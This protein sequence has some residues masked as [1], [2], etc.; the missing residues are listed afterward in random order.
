MGRGDLTD[1]EW[2]RLRPFLPVSNRRCGRWRDHRKVIDGI[3]H[4]VRTGVQWRDIARGA[5]SHS[6][7]RAVVGQS[8]ERFP[9]RREGHGLVRVGFQ[10]GDGHMV[11]LR[12]PVAVPGSPHATCLAILDC[13]SRPASGAQSAA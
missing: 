1:E 13:C 9:V 7:T 4:R 12:L 8:G 6:R 10:A 5:M 3:L 2:E 11:R